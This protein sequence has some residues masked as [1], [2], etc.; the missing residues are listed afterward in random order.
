MK[1]KTHVKKDNYVNQ[2][3][4]KANKNLNIKRLSEKGKKTQKD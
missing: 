2:K 1:G 4:R 3:I